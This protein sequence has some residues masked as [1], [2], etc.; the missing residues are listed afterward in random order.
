MGKVYIYA[1]APVSKVVGE[2]EPVVK[3]SHTELFASAVGYDKVQ[4]VMVRNGYRK[5]TFNSP[6]KVNGNV[7]FE[8]YRMGKRMAV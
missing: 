7:F 8:I 6:V 2:F 1:S 3:F 5:N 4:E